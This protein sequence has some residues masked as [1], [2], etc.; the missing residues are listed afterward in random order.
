MDL[1]EE[2]EGTV[3]EEEG[4]QA[5]TEEEEEC[6]G[7]LLQKEEARLAVDPCG[8]AKINGRSAQLFLCLKNPSACLQADRGG[9]MSLFQRSRERAT[10]RER[11]SPLVCPREFLAINR[12]SFTAS[13]L[14]V[15]PSL[16]RKGCRR[17][18]ILLPIFLAMRM[19]PCIFCMFLSSELYARC[20]KLVRSHTAWSSAQHTYTCSTWSF[21]TRYFER[22]HPGKFTPIISFE[23]PWKYL[24]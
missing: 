22:M 7:N 19:S 24:P 17:Y 10:R 18:C 20:A 16:Q 2:E 9:G 15:G 4:V 5:T 8:K 14:S 23:N 3:E 12:K 13:C 11:R 21:T 1:V 6:E